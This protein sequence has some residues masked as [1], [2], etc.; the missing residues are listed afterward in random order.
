MPLLHSVLL[1]LLQPE[2]L[3]QLLLDLPDLVEFIAIVV[4]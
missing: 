2:L 4:N 3:G 1:H